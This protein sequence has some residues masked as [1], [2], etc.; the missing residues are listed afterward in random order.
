MNP[1]ELDEL[2]DIPIL[3]GE[4]EWVIK[5]IDSPEESVTTIVRQLSSE[6]DST[7]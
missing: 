5:V 2:R 4:L 3:E 6:N 1:I 7:Q